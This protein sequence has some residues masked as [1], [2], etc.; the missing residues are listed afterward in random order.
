[1]PERVF[2]RAAEHPQVNHVADEVYESAMQKK[3]REERDGDFQ[4]RIAIRARVRQPRGDVSKDVDDRFGALAQKNL[5]KKNGDVRDDDRPIDD[6]RR[7]R[8][9][10]VTDGDH[11]VPG[12]P[13]LSAAERLKRVARGESEANT[14]RNESASTFR[15]A[16]AALEK[17][18]L[19]R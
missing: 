2:D 3:R 18:F 4:Y 6:R 7:T 5:R 8:R 12:H 9:E 11:G 13:R 17:S 10:G 15:A 14:P 16:S 1:M 19:C